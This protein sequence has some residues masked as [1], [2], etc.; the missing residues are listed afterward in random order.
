[1]DILILLLILA[2]L[3]LLEMCEQKD[4]VYLSCA[5]NGQQTE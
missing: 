5:E 4:F 1:M 2:G 3:S